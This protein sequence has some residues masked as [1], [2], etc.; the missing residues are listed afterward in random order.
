MCIQL[1]NNKAILIIGLGTMLNAIL[2]FHLFEL[3]MY[4]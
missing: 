2:N 3:N 1:C 4:N